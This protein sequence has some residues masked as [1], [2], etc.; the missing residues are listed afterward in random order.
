MS[1]PAGAEVTSHEKPPR[2]SP[3]KWL[4]HDSVQ[5][6]PAIRGPLRLRGRLLLVAFIRHVLSIDEHTTTAKGPSRGLERML[7]LCFF[8]QER[9]WLR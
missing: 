9:P 4:P 6:K 7:V 2:W 3:I 8:R 5:T 1:S